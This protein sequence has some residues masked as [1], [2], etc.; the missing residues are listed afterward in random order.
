MNRGGL[1]FSFKFQDSKIF[2]NI[3]TFKT[4]QFEKKAISGLRNDPKLHTPARSD[5]PEIEGSESCFGRLEQF[6]DVR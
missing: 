4:L 6:H 2:S 5:I 1:E 3:L